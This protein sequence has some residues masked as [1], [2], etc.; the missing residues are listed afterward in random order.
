MNLTHLLVQ[1][2]FVG[3]MAGMLLAALDQTIVA[4][5]LP[6]IVGDLGG[7]RH[8]SWVVTAYILTS[9]VSVPLWGKISDLLGR[10]RIFQAAI[11][12]FLVGSVFSG[13]SQNM[14]QLIA[15]RALQGI[16]G[17]GPLATAQPVIRDIL[18]P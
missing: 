2:V 11:I 12:V 10:K 7:L 1:V 17:G 15:F 14:A 9:T 13:V 5:A 16:G 6:T 8:L 4:T 3:L 18:S